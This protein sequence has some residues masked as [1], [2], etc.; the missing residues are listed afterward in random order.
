[1]NMEDTASSTRSAAPWT[2][3]GRDTAAGRALFSLYNA[4]NTNGRAAGLTYSATNRKQLSATAKAPAGPS[5]E[6]SKKSSCKPKVAVPHFKRSQSNAD[7][8]SRNRLARLPRRRTG[9]SIM[10]GMQAEAEQAWRAPAPV[11][12]GRLI[13]EQEKQRC[14]LLMQYRGSIPCSHLAATTCIKP[15]GHHLQQQQGF[16]KDCSGSSSSSSSSSATGRQRLLH[17]RFSEL[18]DE[19]TDRELFV[20][21]MQQMGKLR[22]EHL[23]VVKSEVATKLQEM[24]QLDENIKLL[25]IQLR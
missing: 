13:G 24:K 7:D 4:E 1:M 11:P 14:A 19:V 18:A 8:D 16:S 22:T 3:L 5:G 9:D 12:S 17:E 23:I 25:D 10:A 15:V 20:S 6:P 2:L 21:S